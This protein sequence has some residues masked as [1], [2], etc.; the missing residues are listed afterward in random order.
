MAGG[1]LQVVLLLLPERLGKVRRCAISSTSISALLGG[2]L[3]KS[4]ASQLLFAP[5][6]LTDSEYN[7]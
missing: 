5:S 2:L 3:S 7:V 4:E 6:R 1:D